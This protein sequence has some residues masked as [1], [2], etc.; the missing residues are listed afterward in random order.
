[1]A[2]GHLQCD[3]AAV[4]VSEHDSVFTGGAIRH[5]FSHPIGNRAESAIDGLRKTETGKF[6][7]H[8]PERR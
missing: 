8:N 7:N 5:R 6:R 2:N 3:E 1:M 4:T